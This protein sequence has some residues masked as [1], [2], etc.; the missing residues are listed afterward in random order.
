MSLSLEMLSAELQVPGVS[1]TGFRIK[2]CGVKTLPALAGGSE[3]SSGLVERERGSWN[4]RRA[5]EEEG[6]EQASQEGTFPRGYRSKNKL[7]E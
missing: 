5:L 2:G 1:S 6:A 4:R 7:K 3:Q